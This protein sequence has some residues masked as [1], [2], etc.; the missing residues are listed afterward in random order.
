MSIQFKKYKQIIFYVFI[1]LII[2]F[3]VFY[4]GIQYEKAQKPEIEKVSGVYNK[5][6]A[7]STNADFEPF[8]RAWNLIIEKSP[9]AKNISDQDRVYGAI[10]GLIGSLDD[11]YSVFFPPDESKSFEESL[12]GEFGGIGAEVG[13]KD[14]IVTIIAPIKNTPAFHA[15]IK[16]GD[17]ILKINNTDT[18]G[19]TVDK[20]VSLIRGEKGTDVKLTIYQEGDTESKEITITR[21][22]IQIPTLESRKIDDN[23]F[24]IEVYNFSAQMPRLFQLALQEFEESGATKLIIDLRGNPGGFL[25]A[26]IDMASWFLPSGKV[27]VIEDFGDKKEKETHRSRGYNPFP[28][29]LEIIVLVDQGSASASEIFAGALQDNDRATIVGQTT[30]GKGSVQEL[31]PVTKDT[32]LK[33]TVANWLTPDGTWIS[34]SGITPDVIVPVTKEDLETDIDPQLNKAIELLN[35]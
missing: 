5:E 29:T 4:A 1:S 9:T 34:K 11:P 10:Q 7:V 13:I 26:S 25:E 12:S 33:I 30:Y 27:I 20:A 8:W 23:I 15:G 2:L 3:C 21:S 17:K 32:S 31:V 24:I 14:N 19:M 16:S 22:T 35:K 18:N 6:T 28:D